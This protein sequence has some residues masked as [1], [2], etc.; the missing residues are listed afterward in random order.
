MGVTKGDN[1]GMPA[2]N[3]RIFVALHVSTLKSWLRF[4]WYWFWS[5]GYCYCVL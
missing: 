4:L 3:Q 1:G 2:K 5:F